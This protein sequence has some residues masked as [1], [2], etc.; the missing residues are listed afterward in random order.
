MGDLDQELM[1]VFEDLTEALEANEF[2]GLA[3]ELEVLDGET[4][5]SARPRAF[6][7][8]MRW[9]FSGNEG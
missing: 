2:D 1:P 9:V 8:G 3:S 4:H 7:T 6:S 5:L